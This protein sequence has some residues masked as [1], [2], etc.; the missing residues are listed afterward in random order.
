MNHLLE[1]ILYLRH[2]EFMAVDGDLNI[3]EFSPGTQRFA[4]R[5]C[6]MKLG[7]DSRLHFPEFIGL[8]D[9][10]NAVLVGEK[11]HFKLTAISRENLHKEQLYFNFYAIAKTDELLNNDCLL[12]LFENV[13]EQNVLEQKYVQINNQVTL[14]NQKLLSYKKYLQ[15][16]IKYMADAL[17]VTNDAGN[18]LQCNQAAQYLL[19]LSE[20]EVINRQIHQIFQD[21]K[22]FPKLIIKNFQSSADRNLFVKDLEVI[23]PIKS[24]LILTILFNCSVICI[25]EKKH[26]VYI[27]RDIT[28]RKRAEKETKIAL[29]KELE[30]NQ[31][32]SNFLSMT[33]HEFRNPL[34]V[35]LSAAEILEYYSQQGRYSQ[36][37][38]YI[39]QIQ[40]SVENLIELLDKIL[41]I[42]KADAEKITLQKKSINIDKFCS[43]L[44]EQ[45]ELGRKFSRI[46]L[47]SKCQGITAQMDEN[48]LRHILINLLSNALKYSHDATPVYLRLSKE[49]ENLIF[50]IE[51]QGIGINSEDQ[52]HMFELFH[53]GQNVND[54]PGTGLGM[55]IVQKYVEISGGH[56]MVSSEV[57][58]GTTFKVTLPL[59]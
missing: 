21:K 50:E 26:F 54:I 16:I 39:Y 6:E 20:N 17:F 34:T 33:S 23:Y 7:E 32:K 45:L 1:K 29:E 11:E 43:Y 28:E 55:A 10:F 19:G 40:T 51:D 2:L 25:D 56:L 37:L 3:L 9:V 58:M 52:K 4:E 38:K 36:S 22:L 42:G 18:I 30:L 48:L 47:V 13:T 59:K 8:E 35:I 24:G 44:V 53:R 14:V 5:P 27:G 49:K 46:Q 31:I 15:Y 57:G 41:L 12:I